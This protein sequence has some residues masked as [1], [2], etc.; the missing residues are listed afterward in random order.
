[1][2]SIIPIILFYVSHTADVATTWRGLNLG[3]PE[4]GLLFRLTENF[5]LVTALK[6]VLASIIPF[7]IFHYPI[8]SPLLYLDIGV[9]FGASLHNYWEANS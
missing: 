4:K 5:A 2:I 8:L 7:I 3:V 6:Y 9:E 1:M